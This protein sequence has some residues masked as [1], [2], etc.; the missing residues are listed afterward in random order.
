MEGLP[1]SI[2]FLAKDTTVA[3]KGI[4]KIDAAERINS[5][6]YTLVRYYKPISK[7]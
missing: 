5:T 3:E 2:Y 1:L 4:L 7:F 6:G